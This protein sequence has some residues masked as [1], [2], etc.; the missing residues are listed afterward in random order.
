MTLLSYDGHDIM[1]AIAGRE[2]WCQKPHAR[3]YDPT[4][5]G[6]PW[7]HRV[8]RNGQI[9]A[10]SASTNGEYQ[11]ILGC[12]CTYCHEDFWEVREF[13]ISPEWRSKWRLPWDLGGRELSNAWYAVRVW[14]LRMEYR[15]HRVRC[16]WEGR[17]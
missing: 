11:S 12:H 5:P 16:W 17:L 15:V 7:C 9:Y 13:G 10:A 14:L 1:N 8:V 2:C 6:V 4:Q 3:A